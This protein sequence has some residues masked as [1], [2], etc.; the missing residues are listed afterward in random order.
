M[1]AATSPYPP[2]SRKVA[3][4]AVEWYLLEQSGQATPD[5]LAAIAQWRARDP[6]HARAWNRVQQV[7]QTAGLLPPELAVPVLRRPQRRVAV[8]VLLALM[9]APA[10]WLLV[11]H[12]MLADYRS[13]V[14]ERREVSL[15]DGGTVVLNTDSAVDVAYGAG[16]RRLTLRRGEVL[17]Q[18]RPGHAD[19]RPFI[20]ATCHGRI[21]AL[22]TRFIVRVDDDGS[23]VTVLEHAVEITPRAPSATV[24]TLV[25]GQQSRFDANH[26]GLPAPAP[27]QADAWA[28]GMLAV[29]DMR[30]DTFAAELSRYRPGLLRVEP[31]VAGLRLSGAFQL[32]DTDAVLDSLARMLP[33]DVLYRTPYWVTIA[34]GKK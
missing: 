10:A 8:Q 25:A 4:Q 16:E 18:T 22:G 26:A 24:R 9:A 29:L 19:S 15:P 33:V 3:R 6:E 28:R 2:L 21:R 7:S 17:V 30:L 27:L 12:D 20:V 23:R 14:G 11:R 1:S 5:D 32:D 31:Q 34:A 13:G